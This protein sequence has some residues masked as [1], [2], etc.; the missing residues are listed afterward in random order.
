MSATALVEALAERLLERD[1]AARRQAGVA[2]RRDRRGEQ[3]R[4][5]APGRRRP[6]RRRPTRGARRRRRVGEVGRPVAQ[7][8]RQRVAVLGGHVA[9][10]A[11]PAARRRG[12]GTPRRPSACA[13]GADDS[14]SRSGS[15][16]AACSAASAG[17]RKRP[18]RSPVAPKSTRC[19]IT[20]RHPRTRGRAGRG[21]RASAR[22]SDAGERIVAGLEALAR[23]GDEQL[24]QAGAAERARG[25]LAR[26]HL[27]DR[28]ERAV[29]RVAAHR[30][31]VGQRRPRRR[32]P[33]RPSARRAGRLER[34]TNGAPV[35]QPAS[36]S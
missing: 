32:P 5:A 18:A 26:R 8:P 17:S 25:H 7:R 2:E 16:P 28:V 35:G 20:A 12:A 19:S 1:P 29:G 14:R 33:R 36:R 11:R 3:R 9:R 23:G 30:A 34:P 13:G 15:R 6:G 4:A 27:D 10:R 31:A 22:N 24:V 21:R